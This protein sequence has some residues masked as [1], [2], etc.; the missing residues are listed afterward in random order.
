V[1]QDNSTSKRQSHKITAREGYVSTMLRIGNSTSMSTPRPLKRQ[2]H[3][4]CFGSVTGFDDDS[5]P[6]LAF[7]SDVD[8]ILSSIFKLF[9]LNI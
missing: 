3:K 2:S 4:Q 7:Y 9:L 1:G 5:D 8:Q 6:D